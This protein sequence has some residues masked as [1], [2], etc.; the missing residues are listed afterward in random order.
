MFLQA[1]ASERLLLTVPQASPLDMVRALCEQAYTVS[2]RTMSENVQLAHELESV[3][4]TIERVRS[5]RPFRVNIIKIITCRRVAR[6][7]CW[8]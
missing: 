5:F 4:A 6:R 8:W 1:P 7:T 3:R 2:E